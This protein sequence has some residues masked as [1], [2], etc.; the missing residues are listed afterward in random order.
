MFGFYCPLPVC[1]SGLGF[2]AVVID[3]LFDFKTCP[4]YQNCPNLLTNLQQNRRI[5]DRKCNYDGVESQSRQ[6]APSVRL[7][8][9]GM[10]LKTQYELCSK[11]VSKS[12]GE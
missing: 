4:N 9:V 8:E 6:K 1:N 10:L 11:C 3:L 12:Y 5:Y 2:I 7:P